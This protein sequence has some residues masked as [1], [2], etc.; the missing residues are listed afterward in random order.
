MSKNPERWGIVG[1]GILGMTLAHRLAG[2]GR[3]VTL[4]EGDDSLGGLAGSWELG[5][6][7]WDRH[8]H[9]ILQSDAC[10]RALLAELGLEK[11]TVW[12]ET[13]TGFFAGEKF[14]SLSN[15]LEFLRF[16]LLGWIGKVRLGAT[17]FHASR[18]KDRGRLE[19]I[20]ATDWLTR[21]SGRRVFKTIWLPLLRAKLGE[22]Y[23]IASAAFIWSS[24]ARM[25]DARRTGL[26]K[27]MFG[28]IPGGYARILDRYQSVLAGEN[29][30]VKLRHVA[31]RVEAVPGGGVRITLD[32]GNAETFDQVVLTMAAP[33]AS[34]LCQ[35]L[36]ADER[37]RLLGIRYQGIICA[38]LLLKQPLANFYVTN[39]TEEWVPF[40]AVVE[41][42]N[43]VD[44]KHFGGN[45]LVYL[46][47]YVPSGDPAFL[48]YDGEVEETFLEAL[49]RMYPHVRRGDVVAFRV[50]RVSFVL[51]IPTLNY[52][53][54]L[55]PM[56]TS[57][58]GVHIVNSAHILDGT[59]NVNE[60][61]RLAGRA[62]EGL[63]PL[64]SPV[65]SPGR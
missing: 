34:A 55:P 19:R 43:L 15:T 39:I 29:V 47:K 9:V 56:T 17:V 12:V 23:R 20:S 64:P 63:C 28:Y 48:M 58:P 37:S 53:A 54:R 31:R 14:H 5:G 6:V 2:Q 3:E 22:N 38:S 30:R 65:V 62:A 50:S 33:I 35:G 51:A 60:T 11:E 1:G 46:P 10:L 40:T 57:I 42:S 18:L 45:T 13:R 26:K 24:I 52:S 59:L 27:E 49:F 21:W 8:Y 25:Y 44:K 4:F 16:P 41:M 7:V 61:L 32:E 36:E